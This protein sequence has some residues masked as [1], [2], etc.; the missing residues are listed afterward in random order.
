MALWVCSHLR[1]K[2]LPFKPVL[3]VSIAPLTDLEECDRRR[4]SDGGDAIQLYMGH[5]SCL[6]IRREYELKYHSHGDDNSIVKGPDI[7]DSCRNTCQYKLASPTFSL[8]IATALLLCVGSNDIDVPVDLISDYYQL[9]KGVKGEENYWNKLL[10]IEGADHYSV[11]SC[12]IMI[13]NRII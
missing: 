4:V 1:E 9:Y 6:E 7:P 2:Q 3:C 5:H 11:S 10:V 8:P 13:E 12:I